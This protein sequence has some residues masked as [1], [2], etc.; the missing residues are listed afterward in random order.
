MLLGATR[1]ARE[2]ARLVRAAAKPR[3]VTLTVDGRT[4]PTWTYS[5]SS[6][7]PGVLLLHTAGGLGLHEHAMAVRLRHEGF[8]C[9]VVEYSR[10]ITRRIVDDAAAC[11]RVDATVTAAFEC[12]A[13]DPSV[14]P[15]H[16]SVLGLSLGG[17]FAMRLIARS[18]TPP[19]RC[20][21][22]YGVFSS[23][24]PTL[25]RGGTPLLVVQG[26]R[27]HPEFVSAARAAHGARADRVSLL[28]LDGLVHR[29]DLVQAKVPATAE[30]WRRTTAFLRGALHEV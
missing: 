19:A 23:A 2:D 11:A 4:S 15:D 13:A 18:E 17:F 10:R 22:W 24:L 20:V 21:V 29:F 27:D 8:T 12:L 3:Q 28:M 5:T 1:T 9:T 7:G 30:A 14:D 16:V 6:P 26:T 25:E